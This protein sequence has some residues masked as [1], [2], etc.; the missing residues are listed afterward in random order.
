MPESEQQLHM[1]DQQLHVAEQQLHVAPLDEK[2]LYVLAE[3]SGR[4]PGDTLL[5]AWDDQDFLF[6]DDDDAAEA[7]EDGARTEV[8]EEEEDM[9]V[10]VNNKNRS[11]RKFTHIRLWTKTRYLD[12]E[13][14]GLVVR[15]RT[16][17]GKKNDKN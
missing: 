13:S 7:E 14:V 1:A 16:D 5:K 11:G 6:A 8:A 10:V 3:S 2:A 17:R 15:G 9:A 4:R 12:S